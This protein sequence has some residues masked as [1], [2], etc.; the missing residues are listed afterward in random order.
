MTDAQ[1]SRDNLIGFLDF[2]AQR[3]LLKKA[4]ANARKIACQIILKI[5][6]ETEASDLSQINLED[7]I[8]RHRNLAAGKISPQTLKTYESRVQIAINDFIEYNKDPSS[9][10]PSTKPRRRGVSPS[11]TVKVANSKAKTKNS[12]GEVYTP[13]QPS[14]HIDFQ[15]HISPEATPQQIDQIFASM[16]QHL[17]P[18]K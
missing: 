13:I 4:T 11:T 18:A 3:G 15:I 14:V 6:S 8:Q 10:K 5:L 2:A 7:V 12:Q 16:R 1:L 17:Y 9:W